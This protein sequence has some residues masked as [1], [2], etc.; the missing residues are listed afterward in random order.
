MNFRL[1][2]VGIADLQV[3]F[4]PD[5]LR[6][7]L[8]SCVGVCLYDPGGQIG[9][10]SHIM[11]PERN[12]YITNEKKYADSAIP[13]LLNRMLINGAV[14]ERIIAKIVG[15]S[16]MV[17]F[18]NNV[19]ISKIGENNIKMVKNVLNN[20]NIKIIAEDVGGNFARTIDFYIEDG[21]ISIRSLRHSEIILL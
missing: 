18:L 16:D 8:G 9:G 21:K 11:L 14:R 6:T 5:I 7:I 12:Q 1:I 13:L 10:L 3:A 4:S 15:G 17:G 2:N 20:I 19:I